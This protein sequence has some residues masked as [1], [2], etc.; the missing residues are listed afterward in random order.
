M[1]DA[2]RFMLYSDE[3]RRASPAAAVFGTCR[4]VV[5]GPDGSG[6]CRVRVPAVGG[7]EAVLPVS[8][9]EVDLWNQPTRF[10]AG[11]AEGPTL[12]FEDA[13]T[14]RY[15]SLA[16][17]CKLTEIALL[18]SPLVATLNLQACLAEIHAT[19]S[20]AGPVNAAFLATQRKC[21]EVV[22]GRMNLI[23]HV[24]MGKDPNRFCV[25]ECGKLATFG[26]WHCHGMASVF[27]SLLLP[28]C[29]LLCLDVRYRDGF[30]LT[31]GRDGKGEG[32]D[33]TPRPIADHTWLEVTF[34][35]SAASFVADPS[36]D[37]WEGVTVPL[38][39]GYSADGRRYPIRGFQGGGVFPYEGRD[40]NVSGPC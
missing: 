34:F 24:Q 14:C 23:H 31:D 16:T 8:W 27:A 29:E 13:I 25:P 37:Q 6:G 9:A 40:R 20:A 10:K 35:P 38:S 2:A 4:A 19:G 30:Y 21:M 3:K 1:R 18:L 32:W 15:H 39:Q 36:F 28:F 33:G 26:Q 11:P 17:R 12:I 7:G 22:R 5:A